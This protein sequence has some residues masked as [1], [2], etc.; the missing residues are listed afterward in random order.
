MRNNADHACPTDVVSLI[1]RDRLSNIRYGIYWVISDQNLKYNKWF[2]KCIGWR[3][4]KQYQYH[5]IRA[6]KPNQLKQTFILARL[7]FFRSMHI[8]PVGSIVFLTTPKIR[9]VVWWAPKLTQRKHYT[10]IQHSWHFSSSWP[11]W[12][13]FCVNSHG[14]RK[15]FSHHLEKKSTVK[16]R[17]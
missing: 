16:F 12:K 14:I 2:C 8:S 9:L 7:Q 3:M 5:N 13:Q 10:L 15:T 11:F 6:F 1:T 17:Y 4:A